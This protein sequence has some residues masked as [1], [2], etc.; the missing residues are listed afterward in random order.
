M[1][2]EKKFQKTYFKNNKPIKYKVFNGTTYRNETPDKLILMLER[3]R[4]DH[5]RIILDYGDTKTGKSWGED[6]DIEGYLERSNGD[7]KFPILLYNSRSVGGV[8]ILDNCIL[9][10]KTSLG[11]YILYKLK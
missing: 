6:Y 10:I 11:K 7:I 8:V 9:S 4:A 5:I 2:Y 1:K 3:L